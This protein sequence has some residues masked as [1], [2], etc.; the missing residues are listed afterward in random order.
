[1][2]KRK[3]NKPPALRVFMAYKK[4]AREVRPVDSDISNGDTS[5]GREDWKARAIKEEQKCGKDQPVGKY[6]DWLIPKFLD[7]ERGSG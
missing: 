7:I 4:K 3:R 5:G 1:M 2:R 6:D